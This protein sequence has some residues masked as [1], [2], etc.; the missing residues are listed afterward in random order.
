MLGEAM[1]NGS[2]KFSGEAIRLP[3]QMPRY[4]IRRR[5]SN[6]H[7]KAHLDDLCGRNTE[8]GGWEIGVEMHRREEALPPYGHPGHLATRDDQDPSGIKGDPLRVDAAQT[9]ITAGEFQHPPSRWDV[10]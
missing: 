6:L 1:L 7:L 5:N 2:V 10:P 3:I 8:I 4:K 9:R